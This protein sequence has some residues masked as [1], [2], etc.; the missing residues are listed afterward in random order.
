MILLEPSGTDLAVN[1]SVVYTNTG[2]TTY[3]DPAGTFRFFLPPGRKW[4]GEGAGDRSAR[5]ADY[6]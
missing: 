3:N 6:P 1:E 2:K 5:H 4:T